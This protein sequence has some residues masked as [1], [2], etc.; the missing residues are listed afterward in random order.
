MLEQELK[1]YINHRDE[2]IKKFK[3]KHIVIKNGNVIGSYNSITEAYLETVKQHEL[4]TFLI[5][6]CET[7]KNSPKATFH[8][9]VYVEPAV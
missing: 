9:R 1:Y 3:G 4:G 5:Q 7:E 6:F 2:L 8:S